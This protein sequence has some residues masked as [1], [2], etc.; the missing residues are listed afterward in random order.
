MSSW[1][2]APALEALWGQVRATWPNRGTASDG[3]IGD[4]AHA[5]TESDHNPDRKTGVV[6][7][8][9]LTVTKAQSTR[10]LEATV[11]DPRVAYVI[12]DRRIWTPG[13]GWQPYSGSNP[14]SNH[15][16]VSLKH[17]KDAEDDR[18]TWKGLDMARMHPLIGP[19]YLSSAYGNR[20]G[21]LHAGADYRPNSGWGAPVYATYA[22]KVIKTVASRKPGQ[23]N[24]TNELAPFRTGNGVRVQNPDGEQQLY[25][26]VKPAV[27]TGQQV[28]RGDLIGHIDN[29]G[30]TTGPHVHFEIWNA[31]GKTRNPQ[32]DFRYHGVDPF[33]ATGKPAPKPKPK[34]EPKPKPTPKP[35]EPDSG[36]KAALRKMNLSPDAEGVKRYQRA[37]GLWPDGNWGPVTQRYF[38]WVKSLQRALNDWKAVQ[39]AGRLPITGFRGTQTKNRER[40]VIQ[41]PL[42]RQILGTTKASLFSG[43]GIGPE[44]PKRG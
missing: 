3:A 20:G 16:H 22:G 17:S 10:V 29:S 21:S 8:L 12:Y 15:V 27:R 18:S 34:P 26:H 6:R 4:A 19:G 42:N 7:A 36:V 9:D 24:R 35:G 11:G 28:K 13:K 2:V 44:P 40:V 25:G 14:H 43:L 30:N 32:L 37:H 31:A 1:Y 41:P 5:R 33:G 39:R 23:R 38:E